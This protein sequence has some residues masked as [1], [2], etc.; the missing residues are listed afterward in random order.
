LRRS[1]NA[2]VF[3]RLTQLIDRPDPSTG[4][5]CHLDDIAAGVLAELRAAGGAVLGEACPG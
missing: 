2:R 4:F 3:S 1:L 5:A